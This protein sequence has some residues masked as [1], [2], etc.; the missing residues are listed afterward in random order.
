MLSS[1]VEKFIENWFINDRY[2]FKTY[3]WF[4]LDYIVIRRVREDYFECDKEHSTSDMGSFNKDEMTRMVSA[5]IF[6][7]MP[8]ERPDQ[9]FRLLRSGGCTCGGYRLSE[10]SHAPGC[11]YY[12]PM[13]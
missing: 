12:K 3:N 6:I 5:N 11:K 7:Y 13:R 4:S 8:L 2:V 9:D 1:E 10:P